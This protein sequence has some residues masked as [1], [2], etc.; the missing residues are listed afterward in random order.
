M[1]DTVAE[2]RALRRPGGTRRIDDQ[3]R[4]V[5]AR[6]Y[7]LEPRR[8]LRQQRRQLPVDVDRLDALELAIRHDDRRLGVPEPHRHGIW[9]EAR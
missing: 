4:R 9:A 1:Q 2:E 3:R 8:R 5:G 7:R 6:H